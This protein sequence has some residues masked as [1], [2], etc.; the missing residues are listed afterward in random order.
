MEP[1]E[2]T[3]GE[4]PIINCHTHVFTADHVPPFL[5]KTFVSGIFWGV[6]YRMLSLKMIVALFR[7]WFKGPYRWQFKPWYKRLEIALYHTRMGIVRSSVLSLFYWLIGFWMLLHIVFMVFPDVLPQ[8]KARLIEYNILLWHKKMFPEILTALAFWLFFPTGRNLLFFFLKKG[9]SVFRALPGKGTK[10]LVLRYLTIGRF[11]FYTTQ[12]GIFR[13]LRD[14]YPSKTS[15]VILPMDMEYMGAGKVTKNFYTQMEDLRKM[16]KMLKDVI[17]PFLFVDPR[18]MTDDEN[19]FRYKVSNGK[20]VLEPCMVKT[21]I[22]ENGFSGFKIYPALGYYPFDERLLVLWRYARENNIPVMTHCIRGTI[23]YRGKKEKQWDRHPIFQQADSKGKYVPLLLPEMSN[24]DFSVNFTHPLNYLCLLEEELLRKVVGK[25]P[26]LHEVFGYSD[27]ST[28][29]IHDLSKLK[30][31]FAHFGGEDEWHRFF[32]LDRDLY[33]SQ[34]LKNPTVGITFLKSKT[35]RRTD[36]KIEQLWKGCDWY[37]I[38]CSMMLQFDNV[39]ADISY[40]AHDNAIHSLLKSTLK[41]DNAKLRSRVLFGTDFYVVRNHK[42]EKQILSDTIAGLS[43]EEFDLIA[44]SNP[45]SY[46]N[47]A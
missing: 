2:S 24:K 46:L 41:H 5:A 42:S 13:R 17:Y 19:F 16:K 36:G 44:R 40:I 15:F 29:L 8:I 47:L 14:Q 20:I 27:E 21:Y 39:Y 4:L 43:S 34:V 22:E 3:G 9:W 38:L 35:G 45:R 7:K 12:A 1:S 30:M 6:L 23:F 33:S 26:K 37:S 28:P 31:C 25:A 32:E 18:R 10:E 11:A